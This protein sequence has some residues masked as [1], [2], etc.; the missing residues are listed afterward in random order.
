MENPQDNPR[1][2]QGKHK[3]TQ[4][5]KPS[6]PAHSASAGA[7]AQVSL[8]FASESP[9]IGGHRSGVENRLEPLS[10]SLLGKMKNELAQ[11]QGTPT[12]VC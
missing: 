9:R 8:E 5:G 2:T 6:A 10:E 3:K 12:A 11:R 4:E 7:G 1:T